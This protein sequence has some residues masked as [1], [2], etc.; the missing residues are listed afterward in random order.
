MQEISKKEKGYQNKVKWIKERLKE[1]LKYKLLW[2]TEGSK[3]ETSRG[4]IEY[5]PGQYNWR[6]IQAENW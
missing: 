4:F 2:V 6:G 5:I 1:G 3:K